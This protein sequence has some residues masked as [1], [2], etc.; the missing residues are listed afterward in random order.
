MADVV[1]SS[2][3]WDGYSYDELLANCGAA[4]IE[5]LFNQLNCGAVADEFKQSCD[6]QGLSEEERVLQA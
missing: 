2:A 1:T 6:R 5:D 4:E 3:Y